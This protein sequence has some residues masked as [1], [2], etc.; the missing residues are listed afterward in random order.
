MP[1]QF[2]LKL[3][4]G[5]VPDIDGAV[6]SGQQELAVHGEDSICW[7]GALLEGQKMDMVR[8]AY[9]GV[10]RCWKDKKWTW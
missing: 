3:P 6:A 2:E 8:T 4:G 7:G 10:E 5:H 9:V 1:G